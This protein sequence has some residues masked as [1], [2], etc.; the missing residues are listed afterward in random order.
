MNGNFSYRMSRVEVLEALK[1]S[2]QRRRTQ[3]CPQS[4]QKSPKKRT[5]LKVLTVGSQIILIAPLLGGTEYFVS[6]L[7]KTLFPRQQDFIVLQDAP[8]PQR[9]LDIVN[10]DWWDPSYG[11]MEQEW[12]GSKSGTYHTRDLMGRDA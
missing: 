5:F 6:S 8:P 7:S 9:D 4:C 3:S 2:A 11:I 1:E 10:Q 12:F